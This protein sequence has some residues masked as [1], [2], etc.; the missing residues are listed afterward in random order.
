MPTLAF[1]SQSSRLTPEQSREVFANLGHLTPDV[2][3]DRFGW[4]YVAH[5]R[6]FSFV[7]W[8]DGTAGLGGNPLLFVDESY[9]EPR[10]CPPTGTPQPDYRSD[11]AYGTAV[12]RNS[13]SR[14]LP[15]RIHPDTSRF[16]NPMSIG[17]V[18]KDIRMLSLCQALANVFANTTR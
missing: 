14:I 2:K 13:A 6:A 9:D 15:A 1:L 3:L 8:T 16:S 5:D 7:P 11:G 10:S 4:S 17:C 18:D 12:G